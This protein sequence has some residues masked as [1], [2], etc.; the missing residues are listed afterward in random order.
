MSM[1]SSM[2]PSPSGGVSIANKSR[3]ISDV[4][5]SGSAKRKPSQ[6]FRVPQYTSTPTNP[7]T[8]LALSDAAD[9]IF[10]SEAGDAEN[11]SGIH[12]LSTSGSSQG[13]SGSKST[14]LCSWFTAK[15]CRQ[16]HRDHA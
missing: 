6:Q 14:Y 13:Q 9:S 8:P 1:T 16:P 7:T 2:S 4:R 10:N 3:L 11:N 12:N 15:W 5:A